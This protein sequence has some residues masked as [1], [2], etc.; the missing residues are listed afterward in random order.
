MNESEDD[1]FQVVVI[2]QPCLGVS[3]IFVSN[4]S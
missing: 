4:C 2:T 3:L 1:Q